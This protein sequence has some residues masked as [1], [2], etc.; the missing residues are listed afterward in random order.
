MPCEVVQSDAICSKSNLNETHDP[1]LASPSATG[2]CIAA[3]PPGRRTSFLCR[4]FLTSFNPTHTSPPP[5]S[6]TLSDCRPPS[7]LHP[8][9]IVYQTDLLCS[10]VLRS[11]SRSIHLASQL[12][13]LSDPTTKHQQQSRQTFHARCIPEPAPAEHNTRHA[14][15]DSTSFAQPRARRHDRIQHQIASYRPDHEH[16]YSNV[17]VQCAKNCLCIDFSHHFNF[18]L[19][20]APAT[21]N[22]TTA[23]ALT[24]HSLPPAPGAISTT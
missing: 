23:Q 16:E 10:P 1:W 13:R 12:Q 20:S 9:S 8:L 7:L 2:A 3:M 11:N 19:T 14:A 22:I 4:A 15:F 17:F 18:D 24:Q 5:S 6:L 21:Q